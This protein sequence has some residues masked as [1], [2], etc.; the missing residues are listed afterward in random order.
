LLLLRPF[1]GQ[2]ISCFVNTD[3]QLKLHREKTKEPIVSFIMIIQKIRKSKEL[4][5][6]PGNVNPRR[7]T[8]ATIFIW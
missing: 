5:N 4:K 3:I 6:W 8:T 2:D 7:V 1:G